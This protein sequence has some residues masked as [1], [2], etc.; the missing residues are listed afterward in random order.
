MQT[1]PAQNLRPSMLQRYL[2]GELAE[3]HRLAAGNINLAL[4]TRDIP[5][6]Q[7]L[8]HALTT[9]L[10]RMAAPKAAIQN[11]EL[12]ADPKAITIT[13]GQQAGL[14]TGPAYT[15][16]KAVTAINLARQHSSPGRPVLPVF[17][18]AS[19][20]HDSAEI[21]S[22]YL[23]DFN[24]QEHALTLPLPN[25]CPAARI[26]LQEDWK[27]LVLSEIKTFKGNP[28]WVSWI[29]ELVKTTAESASSY[30]D[31]CARVMLSLLG[32]HGL[33]L[34]DPMAP[35]IAP[36]MRPIIAEE[37]SNALEGPNQIEF[38]A[39]KLETMG[40]TPELRRQVGAT[41]LFIE[42]K[43]GQRHLLKS[44]NN[45][46]TFL[47][48]ETEYLPDELLK[49]L[50]NNASLITPAA[51]LRPIVQ[52]WLLPNAINVLGPGELAYHLEL[53]GVYQQHNVPQPLL[54]PRMGATW[55]ETPVRRALKR[56]AVSAND[57]MLDPETSLQH[58]LLSHNEVAEQYRA[59]LK[60]MQTDFETLSHTVAALDTGL[61]K[62]TQR[63]QKRMLGHATRLE[64]KLGISLLRQE[65][66][67]SRSVSLL[68]SHLRPNGVP[69]ERHHNFLGTLMKFG[70]AA[71]HMLLQLE[72]QGHHFLD[73]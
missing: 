71:L 35:E 60:K 59:G 37:L 72:P 7:Q 51:G 6:R 46:K 56:F 63:S 61:A 65:E 50:E 16:Y 55:L 5:H 25:L 14:L 48:N 15:I 22:T 20:D 58:A 1:T 17:W 13:T 39:K 4:T 54:W 38:A 73:I 53:L 23:L 12:L 66:L 68:K 52:D 26:E 67:Q 41:N 10:S 69:Q 43:T 70:P 57:Y 33:I 24:N 27:N 28:E 21:A 8:S 32:E 11:A 3:F 49:I 9:Y 31:W 40:F 30:S 29:Y 36:L 64:T 19:Q 45:G 47:A 18:L 42:T 44:Q 2:A 34:L 62:A